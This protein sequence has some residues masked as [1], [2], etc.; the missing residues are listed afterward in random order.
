M[1]VSYQWV[2]EYFPNLAVSAEELGE[3]ITRGGI[4]IEGVEHL[5]AEISNVVVGEVVTCEKHPNADTLNKCT[6]NVGESEAIQ[7][8][9]GAPNVATGQKSDCRSCW[10]EITRWHENQACEIARRSVRRHDLLATRV[11][12]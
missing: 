3:R 10:C 4:E 9:C 5:N 2:K 11:R 7:I 8:I 6:V 12:L 1:L